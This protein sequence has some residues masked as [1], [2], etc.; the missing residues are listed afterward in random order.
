AILDG[1]ATTP[2]DPVRVEEELRGYLKD[3]SGLA[4]RHPAQTRQILRKLLPNRIRVWRELSNG[5]K[6]Y[7]FEG[8]AAIGKLFNGVVHIERSG[9]P[10]GI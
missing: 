6:V 5:E 3:W 4:Q 1:L 10:N 8:D 2:F 7:R 9:V